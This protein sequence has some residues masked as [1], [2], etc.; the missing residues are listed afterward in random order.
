[1]IRASYEMPG[2]H[3]RLDMTYVINNDGAVKTTESFVADKDA[4]VSDMFRFGMQMQMPVE[5]SSIEYYGRGPGENYSDR[6]S[7]TPI[8]IYRQTVSDQFYPYIRPQETGTKTDIRY[9][10]QLNNAGRGLEFYAENP[11]SASALNY[12]IESLDE[13]PEKTQKHS[14]E[15]AKVDYTN[16]LIDKEQMG[17][18]CVN[19]WGALPLPEYR[20][21]YGDYSFTFIMKP[22]KNQFD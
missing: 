18:G 17:V 13:T 6:S 2:V 15:I 14:T 9:W 20:L 19:S 16:L 5:F 21:P 22:V 3:G 1:M 7:G 12:S 4:E 8:G 10:K 11:F